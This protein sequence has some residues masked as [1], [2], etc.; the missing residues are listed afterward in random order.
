MI[1]SLRGVLLQRLTETEILLEVSGVGYRVQVMPTTWASLGENGSEIFVH[2]VHHVREDSEQLFGFLTLDER[3]LFE[4]LLSAHGVGPSLA[5]AILSVHPPVNLVQVVQNND[6]DSLCLVPGVGKKTAQ[7]LLL[8][9][10]SKL[11]IS[12]TES[13]SSLTTEQN[14]VMKDVRDALSAL[15]YGSE[16][17]ASALRELPSSDDT[18]ELVRLA[19]QKLDS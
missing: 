15:G 18:A 4:T 3:M 5:M 7:R 17:I 14:G 13:T 19:L 1:G 10:S 16:E 2:V 8:E 6:I 12:V 11:D 9:L